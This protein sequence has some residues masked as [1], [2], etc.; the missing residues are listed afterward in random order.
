M[1]S[2]LEFDAQADATASTFINNFDNFATRILLLRKK[3]IIHITEL[4][5]S[6]H[7][8]KDSMAGCLYLYDNSITLMDI[9]DVFASINEYLP[10]V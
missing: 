3:M 4:L 1:Y 10:P 6:G 9:T 5:F 7:T 2:P 8:F